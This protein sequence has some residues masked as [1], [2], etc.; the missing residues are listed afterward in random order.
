MTIKPEILIKSTSF[1]ADFF[2]FIQK[3]GVIGL[4]LGV[5]IGG[6][7]KTLVDSLV[8]NIVNPIIAKIVGKNELSTITFFDIK[9]GNFLNDS[10]NFLLLMFIVYFTIAV[11]MKRFLSEDEKKALKL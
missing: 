10:I 8:I 9:V 1:F 7:V 3:Y 4:A 6:A 11:L 2:H 5:V